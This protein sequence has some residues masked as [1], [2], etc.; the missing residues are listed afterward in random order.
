MRVLV[1]VACLLPIHVAV[2]DPLDA[3][4]MVRGVSNGNA[5]VCR[6]SNI[7]LLEFCYTLTK[8]RG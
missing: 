7:H 4:E 1:I 6:Q 2:D 3:A 5:F 8:E